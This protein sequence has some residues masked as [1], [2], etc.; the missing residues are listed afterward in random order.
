MDHLIPLWTSWTASC[1]ELLQRHA[2]VDGDVALS[3]LVRLSHMTN[4]ADSS[5]RDNDPGAE[6]KV[7][8]ML[9]GLEAQHKELKQA[10]VP[11]L[12]RSGKLSSLHII[13]IAFL[14][15]DST[16]QAR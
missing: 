4:T 1:C 7:Q 5:I 8:L 6:Q 12:A 14:I 10:M 2:E 16:R 9:L 13:Y 11:H 15:I 3:Y